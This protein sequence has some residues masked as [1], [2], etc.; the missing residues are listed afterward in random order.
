MGE[1]ESHPKQGD[2]QEVRRDR[3]RI[4]GEEEM[5][6]E[7]VRGLPFPKYLELPYFSKSLCQYLKRSPLHL[8]HYLDNPDYYVDSKMVFG[9]LVDTLLMEPD[10]F[11]DQFVLQP[12]TYTSEK[13]EVKAWTM[14][15]KTCKSLYDQMLRSGKIMVKYEDLERAKEIIKNITNHPTASKWLKGEK[16]VSLFW[17]DPETKIPCKGRMDIW[18]PGERIVDLKVTGNLEPG[19]FQRI[20]YQ[21]GYNVQAAIYHDAIHLIE[22][23]KYPE[24]ICLA[25]SLIVAEADPPHDVVCF[26]YGMTSM[27]IGRSAYRQAL[28]TY[29]DCI[30]MNQWP[31]YSSVAEELESPFWAIKKYEEEGIAV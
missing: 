10:K 19:A 30:R 31:G 24:D 4:F 9:N 21:M 6:N 11:G 1:G 15:S 22:K 26:N 2:A 25:Y 13:G 12:A 23:G 16:Q 20:A 8:R 17:E 18:I 28:D 5:K 29:A 27:L 3:E 7:I 14:Q